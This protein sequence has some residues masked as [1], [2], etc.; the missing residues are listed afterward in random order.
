M[1]KDYKAA[2]YTHGDQKSIFLGEK[3]RET[4]HK[5]YPFGKWI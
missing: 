1:L 5:R 2:A 4:A 3:F